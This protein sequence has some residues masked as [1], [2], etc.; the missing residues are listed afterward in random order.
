[1]ILYNNFKLQYDAISLLIFDH[2]VFFFKNLSSLKK[3]C[4]ESLNKLTN[5]KNENSLN[6]TE[7]KY[8][9]NVNYN[10]N[11]DQSRK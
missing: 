3:K 9:Y 7:S 1:L 6:L 2:L 8:K 10:I 5:E 4:Y 11:H